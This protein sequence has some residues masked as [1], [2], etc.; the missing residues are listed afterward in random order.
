MSK[1]AVLLLSA[2]FVCSAALQSS[3]QDD[4]HP[5]PGEMFDKMDANGDGTVDI[6]EFTAFAETM[7]PPP[8]EMHD[9]EM[10][11]GE[12]HDGGMPGGEMHDGGMP[13]EMM[14]E[15]RQHIREELEHEI[16]E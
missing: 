12:M 16:R 3:A 6:D 13:P 11:D 8:G 10:H 1:F 4:M 5:D 15:M 7:G 2:G 14:D 9:G